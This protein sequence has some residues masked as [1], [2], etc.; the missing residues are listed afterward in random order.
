MEECLHLSS[1]QENVVFW[2]GVGG[3]VEKTISFLYLK[4]FL[5][6]LSCAENS[7]TDSFWQVNTSIHLTSKRQKIKGFPLVQRY[8]RKYL[9]SNA[10]F[11]NTAFCLTSGCLRPQC[12]LALVN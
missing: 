4:V 3:S 1:L 7:D 2:E 12:P 9:L 11:L 5:I 10:L 8:F 6:T